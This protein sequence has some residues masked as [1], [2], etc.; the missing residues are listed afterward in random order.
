MERCGR[1]GSSAFLE[2]AR[3]QMK[4]FSDVIILL[5]ITG[6]GLNAVLQ[7]VSKEGVAYSGDRTQQQ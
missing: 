6:Y 5:D 1:G 2:R 7:V 3:K 4:L